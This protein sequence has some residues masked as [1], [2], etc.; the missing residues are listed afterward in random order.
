MITTLSGPIYL[1]K[2]SFR[3]FFE[4]KNLIHFLKIYSPMVPFAIFFLFENS[5]FNQDISNLTLTD[6]GTSLSKYGWVLGLGLVVRLI[7]AVVSIMVAA[8]GIKAMSEVVSGN[9]GGVGE[10][11]RFAW[12]RVWKFA[13]LSVVVGLITGLGFV[14]L[15]VPGVLFLV[16]FNFSVFEMITKDVGIKDSMG[17]SKKL[18]TGRF[19]KV[20]GR[21]LVFALFG[22]LF[23]IIFSAIPL[24]IGGAIMP[25]FLALTSLP[26]FL[27]YEEL[28][29]SVVSA[30]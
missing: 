17:G 8:A 30:Q 7:Y 1:I 27:L 22:A 16:W 19:W 25:L 14:L 6:S 2:E 24:G 4:G 23:Q 13:L 20:F 5:I 9:T 10:T 21:V 28:Q 18:V 26:Y 15:I 29:G 3:V 11:F 12:A